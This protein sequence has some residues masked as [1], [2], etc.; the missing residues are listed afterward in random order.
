MTLSTLQLVAIPLIGGLIGWL[1]NMLAVRMLFRP[2][3]PFNVLGL[4]IQ[5]LVPRRQPEIAA[6]IGHTVQRH[7][8]SH[9]DV[10]A[11]LSRADVRDQIDGLVRERI[12]RFIDGGLKSLNPMVGMFLTGTVREKL[13]AMLMQ[14]VGGMVPELGERMV[15]S[16]EAQMDFQKI[17]EEKVRSFDLARLE[18]IIMEIARRELRAIELLGGLLGFLIGLAQVGILLI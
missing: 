8:I 10:R 18:E 16:V 12:G 9:Q 15:D 1:T 3:R 4:R 2:R 7:L 13:E 6:S 11:A 14:E 5:G 17:V